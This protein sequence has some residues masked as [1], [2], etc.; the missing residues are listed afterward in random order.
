MAQ[1]RTGS[2]VEAWTNIIVGFSINWG[3][4]MLILP[5]FGFKITGPQAFHL[6]VIFT[7]ISLVRS[8]ALRRLFN[9]LKF[10]NTHKAE[11]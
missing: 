2:F 4:N 6:G 9:G 1:T 5:M 3:A 10:G 11:A 7:V 8:Y